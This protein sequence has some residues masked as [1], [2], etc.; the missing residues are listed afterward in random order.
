[1]KQRM[2]DIAIKTQKINNDIKKTDQDK[3]DFLKTTCR[4][5][6]NLKR[7]ITNRTSNHLFK[8]IYK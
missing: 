8:R 6:K 5:K 1:M 4:V 7:N 2:L 3:K